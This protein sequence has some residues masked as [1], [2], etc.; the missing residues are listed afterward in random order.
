MSIQSGLG[1]LIPLSRLHNAAVI[2]L[3]GIGKPEASMLLGSRLCCCSAA[4]NP[5]G[6]CAQRDSPLSCVS[7]ACQFFQASQPLRCLCGLPAT[8]QQCLFAALPLALQTVELHLQRLGAA[9]IE[10]CGD[11]EDHH[12]FSLEEVSAAIT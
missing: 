12:M 1:D 4:A 5:G 6:V 2:C 10:A 9:H 11:Y 7:C 8:A 3:L